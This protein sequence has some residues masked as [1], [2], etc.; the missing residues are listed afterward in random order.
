MDNDFCRD[1]KPEDKKYLEEFQ[2]AITADKKKKNQYYG[3]RPVDMFE[4]NVGLFQAL[5]FPEK[6]RHIRL[7]A[8]FYIPTYT[9]QQKTSFSVSL[10][11][12]GKNFI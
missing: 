3:F 9:F 5:I 4:L 10:N 2:D 6:Y 1:C 8:P 12:N 7:P 11:A